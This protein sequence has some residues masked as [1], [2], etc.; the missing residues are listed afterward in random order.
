MKIV[1]NEKLIQRNRKIGQFTTLT[2]LLILAGGLYISFTDPNQ[3]LTAY[4]AL[5][6]GF[7]LSQIGIYFG[8]RWGRRPRPDESL[9]LGLKGMDER[10]TLFHYSAPIPHLLLGPGGVWA[11]IP[12]HQKGNFTFEKG[13][14]RHKGGNLYLKIFGQEGIGRPDLE[15]EN[16]ITN[17]KRYLSKFIPE[18]EFP[19]IRAVLVVTNENAEIA[20]DEAP[21]PGVHLK[22]LKEFI[23]KK[24]KEN[25]IPPEKLSTLRQIFE[26][27]SQK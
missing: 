6:V 15:A 12:Y 25:P 14:F 2:S 13:K 18:E 19:P 27:N 22:K 17:V 11:L 24:I 4:G 21:V 16:Q 26:D 8:N 23:R 1:S 9:S 5:A 3:I 10:H 7:I 20:L